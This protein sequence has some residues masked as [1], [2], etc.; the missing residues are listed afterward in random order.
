MLMAPHHVKKALYQ[1]Y[2]INKHAFVMTIMQK[3]LTG[4]GPL[5]K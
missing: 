5:S 1:K 4:D 2:V 3:K